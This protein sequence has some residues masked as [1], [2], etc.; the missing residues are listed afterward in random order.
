MDIQWV[1]QKQVSVPQ[2]SIA[3][4]KWIPWPREL[5]PA[6]TANSR[7]PSLLPNTRLCK[8]SYRTAKSGLCIIIPHPYGECCD[9]ALALDTPLSL[10]HLL[11]ALSPLRLGTDLS[12]P[13]FCSPCTLLMQWEMTG[14]PALCDPQ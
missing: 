7:G 12:K 13:A 5:H 6:H 11:R 2:L 10:T 4:G 1:L 9:K 14:I 8:R 3:A